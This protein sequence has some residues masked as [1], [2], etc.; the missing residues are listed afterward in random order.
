MTIKVKIIQHSI[1][2]NGKEIVTM[3]RYYPRMIHVECMRHRVMSPSVASSR[4]IPV[5][6][7]LRNIINDP[8]EPVKFGS[9]KP[10]MQAGNSLEGVPLFF[11]RAAW[12]GAKWC[13]IG[14]AYTAHLCGAHKEVANRITEPWSHTSDIVTSTEWDNFYDLRISALAD[15]TINKLAL[16][17]KAAHVA[18]K[19]RVL[20]Q[21]EWHLPYV[22]R[23]ERNLYSTET[24]RQISAARCARV[25]FLNHDKSNPGVLK[26]LN[27]SS[28]LFESRHFS[29]FEHQAMATN[30]K[31]AELCSANFKG[32]LQNR[33]V[34][35]RGIEP[36]L[37]NKII[38]LSLIHI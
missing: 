2:P 3:Q 14:A 23:K 27:L 17:M 12:H 28:H 1:G 11:A 16:A 34:L 37:N 20:K 38:V 32:W 9:N 36:I 24:C 29:P 30:Y 18:S 26:D 15:P 22:T 31:S 4:A 21:G 33:D 8:A 10:G 7:M 5:K 6:R 13:A 25:S 19:S 35:E